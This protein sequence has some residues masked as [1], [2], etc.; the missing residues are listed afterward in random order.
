MHNLKNIDVKF[1]KNEISV[2]TGVSGS[3]KS[4]IAFDT[5]YKEGQF[6]YIESL[7]TY[8]RMFFSL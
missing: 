3:G 7:S 5:V 4:T 6:R 1:P 8:L 2:V